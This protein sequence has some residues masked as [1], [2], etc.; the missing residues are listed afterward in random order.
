MGLEEGISGFIGKTSREKGEFRQLYNLQKKIQPGGF[1]VFQYPKPFPFVPGKELFPFVKLVHGNAE[2]LA[3]TLQGRS[4]EESLR[5]DTKNK[6]ESIAR[7]RDDHIRKDG[8]GV[9]AAFTDQPEDS[10]FLYDRFSMDKVDDTAAIVSMDPAG[11][12]GTAD[13]AGLPLGMEG[14]HVRLEQNF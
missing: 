6:E 1:G 4:P 2:A 3:E 14:I 9:A 11:K 10:D 8:V 5:K 12:R 13:G 7:I